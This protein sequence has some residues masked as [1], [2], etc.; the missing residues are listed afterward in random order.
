[1][2]PGT[3]SVTITDGNNCTASTSVTITQPALPP[4]ASPIISNVACF[5]GNTGAINV[6]PAGGTPPYTFNWSGGITTEDI[7]NLTAGSYSLVIT[8]ANNCTT[9]STLNVTQPSAPVSG[10]T[11]VSNVSCF[12]GNNG[13][14]DLT[15]TGGTGP[16]TYNWVGGNTT[17]DRFN[18]TAG[19]Y[20][21]TILDA[22]NC[23]SSVT[24]TVTQPTSPVSGSASTTNVSCFGANNGIIDLTPTG[25]TAPYSFNWSGGITTEDRFNLSPGGYFVTITDINNC[26]G[27]INVFIG[28]PSSA[29]SGT[30]I[31]TNIVCAGQANGAIDLMPAGGTAPYIYNWGSGISSEDLLNIAAG[32]YTVNITDA[33]GCSTQVSAT[34]TEPSA[35]LNGAISALNSVSCFGGSNGAIDFTASGGTA[36]YSYNWGNGITSEDLVNIPAGTYTVTVTDANNCTTSETAVIS[37]P[38]AI[39]NS[40]LLTNISCFGGANGAIDLT[41]TGGTP[42]YTYDW[43]SAINSEDL[44]NLSAGNY[45]VTVIDA[46]NC[47]VTVPSTLTEPSLLVYSANITDITAS[48]ATDG[49]ITSFVSGGTAPYTFSWSN[50]ETSADLNNLAQGD[51]ILTL[52]DANGCSF[53]DTLTVNGFNSIY[54]LSNSNINVYPNPMQNEFNI[55]ITNVNNEI[56]E[57]SILNSLGQSILTKSLYTNEAGIYSILA[58]DWA[59]GIY[60][61]RLNLNGEWI[62]QI[63]QKAK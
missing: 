22:N 25:G 20:S 41:V 17:Q 16:Y 62:T 27:S 38:S 30:T 47:S 31:V 21:V 58:S 54:S 35:A 50:N 42:P 45:S 6:T 63:I 39:A 11:V 5:G 33:N 32:S 53:I 56:I 40:T 2:L 44:S 12:G 14:I 28:E 19:S 46:N 55:Q 9:G 3:Y 1:L 49:T 51:Y 24:A 10:S 8:D 26:S 4:Y 18:L 15:S 43:G 36:P 29:L 48:G 59:P 7:S 60:F 61:I 13:I 57:L 37:E 34:V 52:T 23:S